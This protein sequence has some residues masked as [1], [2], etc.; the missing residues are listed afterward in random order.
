GVGPADWTVTLGDGV[1]TYHCDQHLGLT[2]NFAVGNATLAPAP[3]PVAV[4]APAPS[5]VPV[6]TPT[7]TPAS[8]PA[9]KPSSAGGTVRATL[10]GTR[11]A[12]TLN[13]KPV[14][15][16]AT[17]TYKFVA[18]DGSKTLGLTLVQTG[19]DEQPLT[20]TTFTGSKTTTVDLYTGKWKVAL[21]GGE[22]AVGFT[23]TS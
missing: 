17:G 2:A 13:G 5:P 14:T 15:K 7:P 3:I 22:G 10:S 11:I 18:V 23:V 8:T 20:L 21:V 6:V 12:L 1:Y 9:S 16:L 19:G 4:A